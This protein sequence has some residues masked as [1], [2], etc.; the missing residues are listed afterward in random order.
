MY[1]EKFDALCKANNV[2]PN[3]VSKAT[4]IPTSTLTN[5]KNGKFTPKIDK[6]RLIAEYF[7]VSVNYFL[8]ETDNESQLYSD[9]AKYVANNR[10][11]NFADVSD[12]TFNFEDLKLMANIACD[13]KRS[14]IFAWL[15]T[16]PDED[17]DLILSLIQ[18]I[19]VKEGE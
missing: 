3:R 17:V 13:A 15:S 2:T 7:N 5:W 12:V 1:Y 18:R 8:D 9:I 19:S 10:V 16:A 6:L 4:G 14:V 11:E